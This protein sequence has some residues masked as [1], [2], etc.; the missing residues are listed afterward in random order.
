M[1][2]NEEKDKS[3]KISTKNE[4]SRHPNYQISEKVFRIIFVL[5]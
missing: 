3:P 2:F 5:L 1:L 4:F